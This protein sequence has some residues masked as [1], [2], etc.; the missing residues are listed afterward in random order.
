MSE[1]WAVHRREVSALFFNFSLF[2]RG[3]RVSEYSLV[4]LIMSLI[5]VIVFFGA[6]NFPSESLMEKWSIKAWMAFIFPQKEKQVQQN[7]CL[8]YE[9][10]MIYLWF[11]MAPLGYIAELLIVWTCK[12]RYCL[13][14]ELCKRRFVLLLLL[15]NEKE[16][17]GI[18]L[19]L[20]QKNVLSSSA[21]C[22]QDN[23]EE[24]LLLLLIS[25]SMVSQ[26]WVSNT[27]SAKEYLV[28]P[29]RVFWWFYLQNLL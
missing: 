19:D 26:K 6:L 15:W 21:Y 25:E 13:A 5:H 8:P 11:S 29:C 9:M 18:T 17:D 22:P 27:N 1:A 7:N 23:V 12:R 4:L 24:S 3:R 2:A 14:N 20:P 16:A 28:F 10:E